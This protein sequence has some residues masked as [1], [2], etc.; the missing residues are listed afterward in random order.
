MSEMVKMTVE[1]YEIEMDA[2]RESIDKNVLEWNKLSHNG[3]G[4]IK[5]DDTLTELETQYNTLAHKKLCEEVS[6][7]DNPALEAVKRLNYPAI[8]LKKSRGKEEQFYT[9]EVNVVDKLVDLYKLNSYIDGGIGQDAT[10]VDM[11][12]NANML[13]AARTC[14]EIGADKKTLLGT[15]K[16]SA[17][18]KELGC[19]IKDIPTSNTKL[20][21]MIQKLVDALVGGEYVVTSA[22]L[23]FAVHAST[24][25]GRALNLKQANDKGFRQIMLKLCHRIVTDA[26]YELTY[27]KVKK[28]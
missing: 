4:T 7:F 20:K 8:K 26:K 24:R 17:Y 28:D 27:Q 18:A 12:A 13:L 6:K 16:I 14:D 25:E 1:E 9:M 11:F 23:M 3:K 21:A 19:D 2:I 15:Y 5:L 10:W 22:D